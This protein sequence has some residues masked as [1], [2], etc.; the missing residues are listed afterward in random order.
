MSN[1]LMNLFNHNSTPL[2]DRRSAKYPHTLVIDKQFLLMHGRHDLNF[3]LHVHGPIK[4]YRRA[5][6]VVR[7][8]VVPTGL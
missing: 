4:I 8:Q 2:F 6:A 5:H 7:A 3:K 1:I